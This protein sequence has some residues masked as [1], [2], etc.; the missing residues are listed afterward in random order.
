MAPRLGDAERRALS[1]DLALGGVGIPR[2]RITEIYGPES[3]GKTTLAL[4]LGLAL[5]TMED[6]R[7]ENQRD[8]TGVRKHFEKAKALKSDDARPYLYLGTLDYREEDYRGAIDNLEVA[9]GLDPSV[10]GVDDGVVACGGKV[11]GDVG[12]DVVHAGDV[13]V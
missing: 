13:A 11:L 8:Y 9:A 1:L 4:N 3:S 5:M 7:Y 6:A 10:S 12:V 2:G